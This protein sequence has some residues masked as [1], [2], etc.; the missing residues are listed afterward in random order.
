[1]HRMAIHVCRLAGNESIMDKPDYFV[2]EPRVVAREPRA[3]LWVVMGD[4]RLKRGA[5]EVERCSPPAPP[6]EY[7]GWREAASL[8]RGAKE[9]AFPTGVIVSG[10]PIC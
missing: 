4:S 7:M 5:E 6:A 8:L 10:Y 2:R 9:A 3:L 1:M